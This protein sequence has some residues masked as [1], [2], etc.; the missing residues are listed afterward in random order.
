MRYAFRFKDRVKTN[1]QKKLSTKRLLLW[2]FLG[3]EVVLHVFFAISRVTSG[4]RI[5]ELENEINVLSEKESL[6]ESEFVKSSSLLRLEEN[7]KNLGFVKPKDRLYVG[8]GDSFTAIL[9]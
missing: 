6:L 1:Y 9:K 3:V 5:K 7:A 2:T 8:V 4:S